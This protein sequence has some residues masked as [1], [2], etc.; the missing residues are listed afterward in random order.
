MQN[1]MQINSTKCLATFGIASPE[2]ILDDG[3][4]LSSLKVMRYVPNRRCVCQA[5]WQG[6]SVYVKLFFGNK[7]SQY[8]LRDIHGANCLQQANLLTPQ[9]LNHSKLMQVEGFAVIFEEIMPVENAEVVILRSNE[10]A[11]LILAKQLVSTVAEHHN[12]K[13]I[14]TD[15]YLKNFLI[16]HQ[17]VYS[18]DGDGIRR[19]NL[20]SKQKALAN[21]SQL[22]SKFDVLMLDKHLFTLL[23]C[24]TDARGWHEHPN[25]DKI[26]I[27]LNLLRFKA[28]SSYADKKVFR[29]CTDVNVIRGKNKFTAISGHYSGLKLPQAASALDSYFTAENV[30]KNGNTCTVVLATIDNLRVVIKRYNI[31][32]FWHGVSRAFRQTRASVSWANAH[33]LKLLGLATAKP[34]ALIETSIGGLKR[35][36]YFLT[37]Y[38]DA[39][40]IAVFFKQTS[41]STLRAQA[42]KYLVE[43]FY[44]LYLLNISH[45]DMKATNIKVFPDGKPLLIDL[46]SM[47]QH[48]YDFFAKKAHVR[49]I[50]RFMLNWKDQPSL[51]NAFVKGFKVVYADHAPLLAAKILT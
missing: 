46:D 10:T 27:N 23:D 18:I 19:F 7:A 43:L 14:Q 31:K 33:R 5:I 41:D 4:V 48:R 20:L 24:Y 38:V 47:Q 32:S 51:Y 3:T 17:A 15:M 34:V 2:L 9:L 12:N 49:D 22:L 26:K 13:L 1:S 50:K 25:L 35:E 8:A 30:I 28:S 42:V 37:E 11:Q 36:A 44:R 6:Q 21:L 39:P 45:G 16:Q 40:D 29:Q